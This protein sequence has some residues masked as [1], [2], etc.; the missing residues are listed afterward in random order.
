MGYARAAE[1]NHY[2]GPMHVLELAESLELS[3]DQLRRTQALFETVKEEA[4]RCLI[5]LGIGRQV[6]ASMPVRDDCAVAQLTG[7]TGNRVS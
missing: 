4:R 3:A 2:P 1:L 7:A 5:I 6:A